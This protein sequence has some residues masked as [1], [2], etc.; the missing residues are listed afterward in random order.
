[1]FPCLKVIEPPVIR[2]IGKVIGST[3]TTRCRT[4]V[5]H[6]PIMT[7]TIAITSGKGGVGKT[8][9]AANLGVKFA[10]GGKKVMVMDADLGLANLDIVMGVRP[11]F[12]LAHLIR[13]EKTLR[14]IV[15]P[16]PCGIRMIAGG[17][18]LEELADLDD[19]AR[20]ELMSSLEQ[21]EDDVDILIID[22][23]AGLSRNVLGFLRAVEEVIVISTPEPSSLADAYGIIKALA[24]EKTDASISIVANRVVSPEEAAEV[25]RRLSLVAR[26]FL[27]IS[28]SDGGYI[29]EDP[30]VSESV[31]Q[32]KPF[33]LV[34]PSSPAAC[35]ID[36]IAGR[37]IEVGVYSGDR[38]SFFR[39]VASIFG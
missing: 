31:R 15:F 37:L 21:I 3:H 16:G 28:V 14:E 11:K 26:Q 33:V 22:T 34:N 1:M 24:R 10:Q 32:R 25:Y 29:Y 19:E 27:G 2:R 13:R 18:G 20:N 9:F 38:P 4:E 6:G 12:S 8:H 30:V 23:G 36:E 35:C 7:R 39:R 17:S 5:S